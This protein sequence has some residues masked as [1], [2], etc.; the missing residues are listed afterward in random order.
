MVKVCIFI[1]TPRRGVSTSQI[2]HMSQILIA[3]PYYECYNAAVSP[4]SSNGQSEALLKLRLQVRFL[5]G[6]L[7][8]KQA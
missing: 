8:K 4:S 3:D 2:L 5:P 1:E 6:A 7:I